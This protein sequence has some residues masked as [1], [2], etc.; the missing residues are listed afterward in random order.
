MNRTN[1]IGVTLCVI[2][3]LGAFFITGNVSAY[4]NIEALLVVLSGTF[5]ATMLSFPFVEIR[6]AW[7]VARGAYRSGGADPDEVIRMLLDMAIKSRM[8]GLTSLEKMEGEA[9]V[10]FLR[11]AL[12]MLADNYPEQEIRDILTTE[13]HF[14]RVRRQ[15]NERIFRAMATY[16]PAFGL[17]GSVIG[18]IGLLVGLGDTGEVLRYIPIALI[19]TLYGILFG[20]F[21]LSPCAENIRAKTDRELLLQQ[22][23]IEG[24]CAIKG[25]TNTHILERK[26]TS[27]LTPASRNE[28]HESFIE[29]RRKYVRLARA[30][31]QTEAGPAAAT[32]ATTSTPTAQ[33]EVPKAKPAPAAANGTS[34]ARPATRQAPA[35]PTA[36]GS[37]KG[38]ESK[39]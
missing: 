7:F 37:G 8:D 26:L 35:G 11:D 3:F 22:I 34:P 5:G 20:N 10:F 31:H 39:T 30:R 33:A 24:V 15:H 28:A 12:R 36:N 25:E 13:S 38:T 18:L 14:F 21:I 4:L 2:I 29:L 17:A 9:T 6:N 27:F 1:V 16:S 19:S 23:I 32:A